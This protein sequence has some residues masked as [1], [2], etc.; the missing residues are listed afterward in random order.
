MLHHLMQVIKGFK[1][2][3]YKKG[4]PVANGSCYISRDVNYKLLNLKRFQKDIFENL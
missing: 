4:F 1:E 2:N 3:V